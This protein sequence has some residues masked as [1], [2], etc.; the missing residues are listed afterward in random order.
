MARYI[1]A[2][3]GVVVCKVDSCFL[4][5]VP[6]FDTKK[7]EKIRINSAV[8][9]LQGEVS[10][11]SIRSSASVTATSVEGHKYTEIISYA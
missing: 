2:E 4:W 5:C 8:Q 9:T 7:R 10:L 6:S 1:S 3:V 11:R